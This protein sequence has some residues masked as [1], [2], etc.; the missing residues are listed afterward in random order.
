MTS[1]QEHIEAAREVLLKM[2]LVDD[3]GAGDIKISGIPSI[4]IPLDSPLLLDVEPHGHLVT[5]R[6][7]STATPLATK[8]TKVLSVVVQAGPRADGTTANAA[9]LYIG[10]KAVA[11]DNGYP[12]AAGANVSIG[13]VDLSRIYFF[14]TDGAD[15]VRLLYLGI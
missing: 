12:L 13:A 15:V 14:G 4:V 7:A 2:E 3:A 10:N 6:A 1:I 8:P 5:L 9:A 11:V